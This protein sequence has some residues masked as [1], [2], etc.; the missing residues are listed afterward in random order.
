MAQKKTNRKFGIVRKGTKKDGSNFFTL[1]VDKDVTILVN[2]EEVKFGKNEAGYEQ[3]TL[4]LFS[5]DVNRMQENGA[6]QKQIDFYEKIGGV[7]DVLL[8]KS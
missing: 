8:P 4:A 1:E 7:F 6:S 3:R 5:V 2:G